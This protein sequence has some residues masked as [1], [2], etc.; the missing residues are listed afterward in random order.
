[1]LA[2]VLENH[3]SYIDVAENSV[4][5]RVQKTLFERSYLNLFNSIFL[6]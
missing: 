3:K 2:F 4:I 6:I 5:E 1:M